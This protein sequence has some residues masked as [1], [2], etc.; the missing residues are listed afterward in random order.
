MRYLI[1]A[2]LLTLP[3]SVDAR[4][5]GGHGGPQVETPTPT[6][7]PSPAPAAAPSPQSDPG[8]GWENLTMGPSYG[9]APNAYN[10]ACTTHID[11]IALW[12]TLFNACR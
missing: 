12:Q 7:A 6:P 3:L 1:L 10:N 9:R 4:S 11:S 8:R 2:L 5:R